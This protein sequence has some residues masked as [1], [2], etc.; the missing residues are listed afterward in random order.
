MKA[1]LIMDMPE[2]CRACKF[3]VSVSCRITHRSCAYYYTEKG[4]P[5]WCP[6]QKLPERKEHL[7]VNS[8]AEACLQERQAGINKGWNACLDRLLETVENSCEHC[9]NM[10]EYIGDFDEYRGVYNYCP[11]CGRTLNLCNEEV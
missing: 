1:V 2:D 4:K 8:T 7:Y 11:V 6:L 5:E 3:N 10:V 9:K